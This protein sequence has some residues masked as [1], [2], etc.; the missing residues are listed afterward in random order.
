MCADCSLFVQLRLEGARS[1]M[2]GEGEPFR[3]EGEGGRGPGGRAGQL[4]WGL[5][6]G[7]DSLFV[8]LFLECPRFDVGGPAGAGDLCLDRA[9]AQG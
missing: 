6:C 8:E 2:T 9:Y 5:R 3:F 7:S 4:G 1:L